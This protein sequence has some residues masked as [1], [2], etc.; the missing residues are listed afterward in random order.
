MIGSTFTANIG[1]GQRCLLRTKALAYTSRTCNTFYGT[2]PSEKNMQFNLFKQPLPVLESGHEFYFAL[3]SCRAQA[4][5]TTFGRVTLSRMTRIIT[6]QN[7][8][9]QNDAE[10][11]DI[12]QNDTQLNNTHKNTFNRETIALGRMSLTIMT[13]STTNF[14]MI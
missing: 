13:L 2:E 3:K 1:Q 6:Q 11:K 10:L 8:A 5:A 4:G 14:I 12:Q 7:N 9:Q